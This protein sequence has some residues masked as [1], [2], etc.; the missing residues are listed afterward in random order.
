M[1]QWN[2]A[3]PDDLLGGGPNANPFFPPQFLR[4]TC[5][6]PFP[7][8]AAQPQE[9][10]QHRQPVSLAKSKG[11]D[12]AGLGDP[13]HFRKIAREHSDGRKMLENAVGENQIRYRVVQRRQVISV[14]AMEGNIADAL[15]K[16]LPG[17]G[18][19]LFREVNSI[20]SPHLGRDGLRHATYTTPNINHDVRFVWSVPEEGLQISPDVSARLPK[21]RSVGVL[22]IDERG[23]VPESILFCFSVPEI[24]I[25]RKVHRSALPSLQCA[26]IPFG[27]DCQPQMET[28]HFNSLLRVLESCASLRRPMSPPQLARRR[29]HA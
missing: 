29:E 7:Q 10:Q 22:V 8:E 24:P 12:T 26:Y 18:K 2:R 14:A 3:H 5:S 28:E 15:R 13:A 4:S 1:P 17:T 23:H 27:Q 9:R 16:I 25:G 21:S 6:R 11:Y 19:H 20:H